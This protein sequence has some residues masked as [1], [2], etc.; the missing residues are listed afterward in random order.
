MADCGPNLCW[1]ICALVALVLMSIF[2]FG[3]VWREATPA[4]PII[5][6]LCVIF[7]TVFYN[8]TAFTDPGIIPRRAILE[9][10]SR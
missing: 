4:L 7:T 9:Y 2:V 3:K 5:F 8:L 6:C 10:L 1:Y